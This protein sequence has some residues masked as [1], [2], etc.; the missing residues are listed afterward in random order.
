MKKTTTAI[1]KLDKSRLLGDIKNSINYLNELY[2]IYKD[3]E[4]VNIHIDL[5]MYADDYDDAYNFILTYTEIETDE[6]YN[7]RL[8]KEKSTKQLE[9]KLAHIQKRIRESAKEETEL[10]KKEREIQK[11]LIGI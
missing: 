2:N 7:I 4:K 3:K 9:K 10:I 5:D 1:V 6:E 8:E 11:K